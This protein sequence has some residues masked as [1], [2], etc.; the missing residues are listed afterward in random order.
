MAH[1]MSKTT[2]GWRTSLGTISCRASIHHLSSLP[3]RTILMQITPTLIGKI[4]TMSRFRQICNCSIKRSSRNTS[5]ATTMTKTSTR[6]SSERNTR[7]WLRPRG[8]EH[9]PLL[10]SAKIAVAMR[11]V[12]THPATARPIRITISTTAIRKRARSNQEAQINS[13]K[14]IKQCRC[15]SPKSNLQGRTSTRLAAG[16]RTG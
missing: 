8:R 2:R 15:H 3:T 10:A 5:R 11:V 12:S 14:L 16:I 13:K 1:K 9:T 7:F 4:K 6:S